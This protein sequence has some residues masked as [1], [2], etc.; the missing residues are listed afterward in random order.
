MAQTNA[1]QFNIDG[2]A[3][4]CYQTDDDRLWRCECT[5]FQRML[6]EHSQGFCPHVAL[7]IQDAI[8]AGLICCFK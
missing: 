7:A 1:F 8:A 3:V 2:Q 4:L 6:A 5:Y